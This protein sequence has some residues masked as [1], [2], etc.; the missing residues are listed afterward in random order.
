MFKFFKNKSLQCN[1]II[2]WLEI[3]ALMLV[4]WFFMSGIIDETKFVVFGILASIII[5]LYVAPLFVIG[6]IKTDRDYFLLHANPVKIFIYFIWLV[7]EIIL[8]ALTVAKVVINPKKM[9]PQLVWFKADYDNPA[10]RALLANSIT[11]TPGTITVDIYDDG[12][13]SCHCLTDDTKEGLLSG[14]MQEKVAKIFGEKIDY[15]IVKVIHD[16]TLGI[17]EESKLINNKYNNPGF[18]VLNK[19]KS[20]DLGKI[21]NVDE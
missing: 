5:S 9:Q 1:P 19:R 11:L 16:D 21:G 12:V 6:G 17:K 10:A 2:H 3:L 13:Y 15:G 18:R 7:K 20:S 8:S 4:L 14:I